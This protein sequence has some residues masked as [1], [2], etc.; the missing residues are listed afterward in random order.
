MPFHKNTRSLA[1]ISFVLPAF[2]SLGIVA[3]LWATRGMVPE[4]LSLELCMI[5]FVSI[6]LG[7][8]LFSRV[9]LSKSNR[10][11]LLAFLTALSS[12]SVI[13]VAE[14]LLIAWICPLWFTVRYCLASDA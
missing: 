5:G 6:A 11:Y 14:V 12:A 9:A 13:F 10:L 8:L 2:L 1:A 4:A 7:A 3:T